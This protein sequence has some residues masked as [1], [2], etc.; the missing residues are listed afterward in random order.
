M[1]ELHIKLVEN[2]SW[3]YRGQ[4]AANPHKLQREDLVSAGLTGLMEAIP[5]YDPRKGDFEA[6]ARR[7]VRA[8]MSQYLK[9]KIQDFRHSDRQWKK[10][11][12]LLKHDEQSYELWLFQNS[13]RPVSLEEYDPDETNASKIG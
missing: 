8:A 3:S 11:S 4:L 9:T 1:V 12:K 6:Y 5:R 13:L 10:A 7:Y 2:I